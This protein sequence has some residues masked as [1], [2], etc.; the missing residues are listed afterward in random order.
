MI[1]VFIV[2]SYIFS[3]VMFVFWGDVLMR[4]TG[5]DY[6]SGDTRL[7]MF[8]LVLDQINAKVLLNRVNQCGYNILRSKSMLLVKTS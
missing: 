6:G 2:V 7:S 1:L 4:F 8:L 3:D 5:N